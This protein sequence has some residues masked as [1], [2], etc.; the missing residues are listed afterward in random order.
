MHNSTTGKQGGTTNEYYH[1]TSAEHTLATQLSSGT[2]T[3][4]L[5]S[6]D[7]L[8]FNSKQASLGYTAANDALVMHTAT[9]DPA[10]GARQVAF[11][12][13]VQTALNGKQEIL[14]SGT[15]IKTVNGKTILGAGGL[16]LNADDISDSSTIN[17]F[18]NASEKSIWN[19]KQ[20]LLV[21]G[22]NIKTI[23]NIP[24]TGSGNIEITSSGGGGSSNWTS[25]P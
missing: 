16:V 14:V 6:T 18:T 13:S 5:S 15:N 20:D 17:K 10:G 24:V 25:V 12:D 23:N 4:L 2:L 1:L 9:Y 8:T 3:G 7:W 21:S 19:G 22:V 11:A